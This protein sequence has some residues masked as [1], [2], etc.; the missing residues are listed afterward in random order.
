MFFLSQVDINQLKNWQ[1]FCKDHTA[2]ILG[3]MAKTTLKLLCSNL[4]T[5]KGK[6]SSTI[7]LI[8]EIQNRKITIVYNF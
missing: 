8:D 1:T 6:K 5:R 4:N 2:N 3:S 7:F